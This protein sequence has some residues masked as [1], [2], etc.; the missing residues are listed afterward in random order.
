MTSASPNYGHSTLVPPGS[1]IGKV[2][3]LGCGFNHKMTVR[4]VE[5]LNMTY[6]LEYGIGLPE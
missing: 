3:R 2:N 6:G 5:W 4:W 1:Q